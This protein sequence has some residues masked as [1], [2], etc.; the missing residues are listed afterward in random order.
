MAHVDPD[1]D[2]EDEEEDEGDE[3]LEDDEIE[4][5]DE[6]PW[7]LDRLDSQILENCNEYGVR[8]CTPVS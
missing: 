1:I 7:E 6:E 4:D 3:E 2:S 8:K 5:E